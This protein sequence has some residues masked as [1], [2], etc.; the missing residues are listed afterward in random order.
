MAISTGAA[1]GGRKRPMAEINITPFTD[2]CLVLLIIFM[3]SASF[4]GAQRGLDIKLPAP[5]SDTKQDTRPVG[6]ITLDVS[7]GGAVKMTVTQ[8]G[9]KVVSSEAVPA[10]KLMNALSSAATQFKIQT[11]T[12]KE[13][14]RG[15]VYRDII[16]VMDT[17]K[18]AGIEYM[19][20]AVQETAPTPT[21]GAPASAAGTAVSTATA[22]PAAAPGAPPGH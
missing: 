9:G 11:V 14:E 10:E 2:V 3:V 18:E 12:I 8:A 7:K 17:V 1:P 6:D 21:A 13:A 15:V 22:S 20:L 19:A 4:M 16:M 5:S